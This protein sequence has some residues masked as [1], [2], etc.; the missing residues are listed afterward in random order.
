MLDVACRADARSVLRHDK[1]VRT[2]YHPVNFAMTN[3][4]SEETYGRFLQ[5]LEHAADQTLTLDV[6]TVVEQGSSASVRVGDWAHIVAATRRRRR[7]S[8]P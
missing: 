7:V 6:G 1:L 3:A 8:P 4:E 5:S 2:T